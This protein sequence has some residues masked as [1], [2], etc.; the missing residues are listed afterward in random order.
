M[1]IGKAYIEDGEEG[2][3]F[4]CFFR[5]SCRKNPLKLKNGQKKGVVDCQLR[6][7]LFAY[8]GLIPK[9]DT[10][11]LLNNAAVTAHVRIVSDLDLQVV[12]VR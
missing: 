10:I 11:E 8:R 2:K 9:S 4:Y 6:P 3:I 5:N 12:L 7:F 1:A